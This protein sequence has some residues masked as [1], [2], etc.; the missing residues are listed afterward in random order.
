[1]PSST[2]PAT[3]PYAAVWKGARGPL[4][5]TSGTLSTHKHAEAAERAARRSRD[6]LRFLWPGIAQPWWIWSVV[7]R[8]D[9][10]VKQL[11]R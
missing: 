5:G 4:I 1:M 2:H 7:D 11:I 9:G 6:A 10:T 8:R 3:H